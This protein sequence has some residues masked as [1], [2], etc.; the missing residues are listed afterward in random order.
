MLARGSG[1]AWTLA[2]AFPAASAPSVAV[3]GR[4]LASK[5]KD[6]KKDE[7]DGP[8]V[9]ID[10]EILKPLSSKGLKS[11]EILQSDLSQLRVGVASPC[12]PWSGHSSFMFVLII[13]IFCSA[14]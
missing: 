9:D 14:S 12:A 10:A 8:S 3:G 6:S 5:K 13:Y 4:F 2:R 11:M 1:A 7:D